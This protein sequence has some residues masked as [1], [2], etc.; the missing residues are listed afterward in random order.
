M[1]NGYNY[2]LEEDTQTLEEFILGCAKNFGACCH[3][4]V[5]MLPR[6]RGVE[7]KP[8]DYN[9]LAKLEIELENARLKLEG[10]RHMS[11]KVAEALSDTYYAKAMKDANAKIYERAVLHDRM[12]IMLK[13]AQGWTV[14]SE[15]HQE[16]KEF[17]LNQIENAIE[18]DC[19]SSYY[20]RVVQNTVHQ[21]GAEYRAERIKFAEDD[22]KYI[23][24]KIERKK[25]EAETFDGDKWILDLYES[26]SIEYPYK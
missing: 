24:E 5:D 18:H 8:K 15:D 13:N 11:L 25:N 14:P 6:C 9:P 7:P 21:S 17:A 23:K 12:K 4:R 22:V 19:D 20:Q 1:P 3:Q 2:K 26:L 16:L 10:V